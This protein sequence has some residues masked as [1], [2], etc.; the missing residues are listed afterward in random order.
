MTVVAVDMGLILD[1]GAIVA[2]SDQLI[3]GRETFYGHETDQPLWI[4]NILQ[5][6]CGSLNL[7]LQ[8]QV[9]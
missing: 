5:Q 2:G 7:Q 4:R 9:F 8:R 1:R 6:G 3:L